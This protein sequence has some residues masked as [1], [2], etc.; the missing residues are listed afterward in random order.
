MNINHSS[1]SAAFFGKIEAEVCK[2]NTNLCIH[3]SSTMRHHRG[4]YWHSYD[5]S[6]VF[7]AWETADSTPLQLV[8]TFSHFHEA[9]ILQGR[10]GPI[11]V[12]IWDVT[13]YQKMAE[14]RE[15]PPPVRSRRQ[16]STENLC[17][18]EPWEIIFDTLN[19]TGYYPRSLNINMCKGDCPITMDDEHLKF[20]H[21]AV[22]HTLIRR[23]PTDANAACCVPIKMGNAS[24]LD[25][26]RDNIVILELPNT[27]AI[28]CGC[29]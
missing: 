2:K 20:R 21:T 23:G 8:L 28:E 10:N 15:S 17:H 7:K 5:V 26:V 13:K 22:R 4:S 1:G 3:S 14:F 29:L 24:V 6:D 25:V 27:V 11:M 12:L 16:A 18:L 9:Y 19:I